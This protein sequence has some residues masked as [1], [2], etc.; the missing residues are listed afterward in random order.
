MIM[1]ENQEAIFSTPKLYHYI[2]FLRVLT[3]GDYIEYHNHKG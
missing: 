2:L 3:V 1:E